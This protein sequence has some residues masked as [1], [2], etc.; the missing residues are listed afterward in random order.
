MRS[1]ASVT[2]ALFLISA[3]KPVLHCLNCV[4]LD[5]GPQEKLEKSNFFFFAR[6]ERALYL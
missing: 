3:L 2:E 1:E 5:T 4:A 6:V